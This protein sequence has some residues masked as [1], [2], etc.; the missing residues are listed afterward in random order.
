MANTAGGH[1]HAPIDLTALANTPQDLER[2][3]GEFYPTFT[4]DYPDWVH[5]F[6]FF[7]LTCV[8]F[9]RHRHQP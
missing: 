4:P 9:V 2:R 3:Y 6:I 7:G 5:H 1:C 8:S